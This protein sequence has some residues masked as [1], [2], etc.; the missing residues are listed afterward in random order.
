MF[1]AG[2]KED[3]VGVGLGRTFTGLG[4]HLFLGHMLTSFSVSRF[5]QMGSSAPGLVLNNHT[6]GEFHLTKLHPPTEKQTNQATALKV[7]DWVI[8]SLLTSHLT[9]V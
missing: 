3:C 8:S 4:F 5:L 2:E 1:Q 7:Y 9:L 6:S